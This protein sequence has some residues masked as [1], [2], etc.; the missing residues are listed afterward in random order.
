MPGSGLSRPPR[1]EVAITATTTIDLMSR[2]SFIAECA[3][4][5]PEA[6]RARYII[7][8]QRP[9][10]LANRSGVSKVVMVLRKIVEQNRI[11][12]VLAAYPKPF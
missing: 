8:R 12:F 10:L 9:S 1:H 11:F 7:E 3:P 4:E 6:R 5:P 2:P